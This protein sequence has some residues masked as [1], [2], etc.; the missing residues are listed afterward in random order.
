MFRGLIN[1]FSEAKNQI[2][3]Q[4]EKFLLI[5]NKNFFD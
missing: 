1:N 2:N 3:L 5:Q 4:P